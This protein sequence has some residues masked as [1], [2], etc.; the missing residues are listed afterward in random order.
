MKLTV[1][2]VIHGDDDEPDDVREVFTVQREA[3]T[4]DTL[5]LQL[6]EAKDLNTCSTGST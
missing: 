4:G 2:V 6:A 3:L 1:Q 5:G